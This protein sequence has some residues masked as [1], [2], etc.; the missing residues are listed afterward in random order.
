[1]PTEIS[2]QFRQQD[3]L[4]LVNNWKDFIEDKVGAENYTEE[5]VYPDMKSTLLKIKSPQP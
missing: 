2:N 4:L 1:M 5:F 3:Y